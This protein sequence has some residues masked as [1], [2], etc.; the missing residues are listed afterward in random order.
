[1]KYWLC[2]CRRQKYHSYLLCKH[3]VQGVYHPSANW[4]A[5]IIWWH[6]TPFY[7]TWCRISWRCA[8]AV[9][10]KSGII[11]RVPGVSGVV[12]SVRR[13]QESAGRIRDDW[14]VAEKWGILSQCA[15]GSVPREPKAVCI[16]TG[17]SMPAEMRLGKL[18]SCNYVDGHTTQRI[19]LPATYKQPVV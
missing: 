9:G 5:D 3:L 16:H 7:D 8:T 2:S 17:G 15:N 6:T 11:P 12:T 1:M 18:I 10:S 19:S 14:G 13:C 4:W